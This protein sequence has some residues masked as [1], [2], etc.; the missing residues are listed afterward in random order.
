MIVIDRLF[1]I[2]APFNCVGCGVEGL[3]LCPVCRGRLPAIP[4]RCYRCNRAT[5]DFR[6]C[7]SCR[8]SSPLFQVWAATSYEQQAKLLIHKLKFERAQAAAHDVAASI[9]TLLPHDQ[10][11]IITHVPTASARVRV[12][13]YDQAQLIAKQLARQLGCRYL[14]LLARTI[15]VRQVGQGGAAR[16][17]QMKHAFRAV[18]RGDIASAHILLVDDVITTGSTCEA[19]AQ[20]LRDTGAAQVSAAVFAAA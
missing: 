17:R 16:R 12:R 2:I 5:P 10:P 20:T 19:A 4:S 14:P 1:S 9:A 8:H 11:W 6:T 3:L 18:H 15:A 7:A 13:G